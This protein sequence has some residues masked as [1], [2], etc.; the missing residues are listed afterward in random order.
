MSRL[1]ASIVALT[2]FVVLN[3]TVSAVNPV[4]NPPSFTKGADQTINEDALRRRS[5]VG[6]P[7]STPAQVI[8]ARRSISS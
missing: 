1:L 7:T 6:P 4:N 8:R 3:F 2:A 5:M